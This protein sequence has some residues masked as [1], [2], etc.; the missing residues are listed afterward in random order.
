V[1]KAKENV[2]T[3]CGH[4]EGVCS[5]YFPAVLLSG[6]TAASPL[7]AITQRRQGFAEPAASQTPWG[8]SFVVLLCAA[9]PITCYSVYYLMETANNDP[10]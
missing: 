3:P 9:I 10:V 7:K 6:D 2:Q 5:L 8:T 1:Q 4:A